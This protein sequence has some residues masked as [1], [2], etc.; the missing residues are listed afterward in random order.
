MGIILRINSVEPTVTQRK[1]A[2]EEIEGGREEGKWE[3]KRKHE[4][5]SVKD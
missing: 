2:K 1:R 5:K 3:T 4:R